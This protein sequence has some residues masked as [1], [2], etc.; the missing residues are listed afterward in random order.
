MDASETSAL[1]ADDSDKGRWPRLIVG[2]ASGLLVAPVVLIAFTL[3]MLPALPIVLVL[4]LAVGWSD[5]VGEREEEEEK[6]GLGAG[7]NHWQLSR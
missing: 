7:P 6:A 2:I 5:W 4:G 3:A 1:G